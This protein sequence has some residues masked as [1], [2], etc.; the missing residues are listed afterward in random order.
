MNNKQ[1]ISVT[2][3]G[4]ERDAL[5][6]G[7]DT[8]LTILRD[9]LNLTGTKRG[10]NQGVC[11]ACTVMVDGVAFRSCLTMAGFCDGA[12]VTTVEGLAN[13]RAL[14]PVQTAFSETGA[15]QC[16]FCTSGMMITVKAFLEENP[17]P[18][19]AEIQKGISGNLCRCSG[20]KKIIDATL[21]AARLINA[22][23]VA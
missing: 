4:E 13:N 5:V 11:G 19:I 16:G 3:N 6:A 14:S 8:L 10:C 15:V 12:E 17:K 1:A 20:Y 9:Q 18:T 22:G 21:E 7:K 23:E 2:V